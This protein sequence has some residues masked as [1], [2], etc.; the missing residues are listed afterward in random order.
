MKKLSKRYVKWLLTGR[1]SVKKLCQYDES[2]HKFVDR[3]MP[4]LRGKII[5]VNGKYLFDSAENAMNNLK[6]HVRQSLS[7]GCV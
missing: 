4:T 3:Y 2:T 1:K 5:Q 7:G 6:D